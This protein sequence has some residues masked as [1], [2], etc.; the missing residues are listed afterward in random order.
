M[1][2][3]LKNK[4]VKP[5]PFPGVSHKPRKTVPE[6]LTKTLK[7]KRFPKRYFGSLN[8]SKKIKRIEELTERGKMNWKDPKAYKQF[9]TDKGGKTKTSKY[10]RKMRKL[11]EESGYTPDQYSSLE[12]KSDITGIPVKYL[13]ECSDRGAAAWAVSGHR[14]F[15]SEG[16]WAGARVASLIVC[17]KTHYSADADLVRKA[18]EESP[19]AK[20]F[21]S[22]CN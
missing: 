6:P 13:K 16:A 21:W 8:K 20:K 4:L 15:A 18:I 14:P 7:S 3:T 9:E 5:S 2:K 1:K 10:V 22:K 12:Q 11:F 17:G 19:K